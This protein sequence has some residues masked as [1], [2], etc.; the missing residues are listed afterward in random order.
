MIAASRTRVIWAIIAAVAGGL[1]LLAE[2]TRLH[3]VDPAAF[4][5]IV[6]GAAAILTGA[7]WWGIKGDDDSARANNANTR[8]P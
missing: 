2:T 5:V 6:A 1:W 4:I 7:F 8:T 3:L